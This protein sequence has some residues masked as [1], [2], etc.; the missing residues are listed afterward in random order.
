MD[1]V[2]GKIN[3]LQESLR[4]LSLHSNG[5]EGVIA[6]HNIFLG[7]VLA[8]RGIQRFTIKEIITKTWRLKAKV[9]IEKLGENF[10]KFSFTN[11]KDIEMVFRN[12]HWCLNGAHLI[13]KEWPDDKALNEISFNTFTFFPLGAR[14]A[15]NV[16]ES[17]VYSPYW[18][19]VGY[20]SKLNQ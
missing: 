16:H 4:E 17:L 10:F 1:L 15:P 9:R 19:K 7:K 3:L 20:P 8:T 6:A 11:R 5:K 14:V 13:L 18:S 2:Q 12:R